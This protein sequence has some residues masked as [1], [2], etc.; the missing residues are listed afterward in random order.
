MTRIEAKES[1]SNDGTCVNIDMDDWATSA[2][3]R[4]V[5]YIKKDFAEKSFTLRVPFQ[6][7][8]CFA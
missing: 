4:Q 3:D 8:F 1:Y 2:A 6:P 7:V 5:A